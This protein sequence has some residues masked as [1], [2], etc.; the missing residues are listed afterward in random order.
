L[1]ID[2]GNEIAIGGVVETRQIGMFA[3]H[4]PFPLSAPGRDAA[5]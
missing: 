2:S 1:A 4:L 3:V 5:S